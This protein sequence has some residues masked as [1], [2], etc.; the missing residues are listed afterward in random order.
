ME[1]YSKRSKSLN[2]RKHTGNTRPAQDSKTETA[3]RF[4]IAA[5]VAALLLAA[6]SATFAFAQVEA[7]PPTQ[8]A[9]RE[10]AYAVAQT[11]QSIGPG[12]A[13]GLV[14]IFT[15]LV[16]VFSMAETA[17]TA[18]RRTRVEQLVDEKRRGAGAVRSLVD[19]A[20][21]F[22]A[23]VQTGITLFGLAAAAA[24]ATALAPP[25][26]STLLRTGLGPTVSVVLSVGLTTLLTAIFA[27]VVGE[28]APKSL[29]LQAPDAWALR[30]APFV[31]LCAILFAPLTG[32]VVGLSN[33][34]VG[35]FGARARFET[36]MITR[37]EFEQIIDQGEQH[38]ELDDEE[39]KIITNVFDLSETAV[40]AVMTPRP[41]VTALPADSNLGRTL[42]TILTSG[43]S[44]IPVYEGTVD[45][46]IG[47][48]HAKDLLRL[49]Q[50]GKTGAELRK[51]MRAA[52][53]IPETKKVRDLLEEFR[54]SNQQFAVVQDEYAGTAGIVTIE[55]LLEEIVGDIRD[56]YDVD[57]PDVQVISASESLIDGRMGILDV[58]ERLGVELPNDE[59]DTIGGLVFGLLG[60]EPVAGERVRQDGI[61]FLVEHVEGRRIR[62]LRAVKVG[63]ALADDE[64]DGTG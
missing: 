42:D 40:R 57:E 25:L 5:V 37:E 63:T 13:A 54:R 23:T 39:A 3:R 22:V 9:G 48:V 16:G 17:I 19:N 8:E 24:A 21:R 30:L 33:L 51:V 18:M 50:E 62:S 29:A 56:E 47:I 36:P 41:D 26:V 55:D 7:T 11:V 15:L 6:F 60:H 34:L 64:E 43:H 38:G 49:F 46:V 14:L 44:R 27:M 1:P 52:H 4:P 58:N 20:P 31:Q 10:A 35:P 12:I 53:F 2:A 28:I 61:E 59:Y 32:L 45:N